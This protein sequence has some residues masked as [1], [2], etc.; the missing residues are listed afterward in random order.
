MRMNVNKVRTA[1]FVL[2]KAGLWGTVSGDDCALRLTGEEWKE[3]YRLAGKQTVTGIVFD[4]MT[5][6]PEAC[7]PPLPLLMKW[8]AE[9]DRVERTNRQMNK[10]TGELSRLFAEQGI[11]AVLLKGQGVAACYQVPLHRV[12]GD[13]DW[14]FPAGEDWEKAAELIK[15]Q[16]VET[17]WQPGFSMEYQWNGCVI[18]HHKRVLDV[19]NPFLHRYVR[20]LLN[21]EASHGGELVIGGGRVNLLS[22]LLVHLSVNMHILK[23]MLAVGIGIR[24]LCDVACIY[25]YY[26]KETDGAEL[27]RIYHKLGVFRWIQVLDAVLVKYLGVPEEVL[28]FPLAGDEQAEWMM[29]DILRA[30]NFGFYDERFSAGTEEGKGRRKKVA[31]QILRRFGMNVCYAPAE[32]CWFPVVQ[33]CSHIRFLKKT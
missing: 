21:R 23:H 28:P 24:Q 33:A 26:N 11:V 12:C 8:T 17:A 4:G 27:K 3:L 1:F 16:G 25:R 14:C 15:H 5:V 18:E 7:L 9:V 20:R 29:E 6:M 31:W 19:H 2:L 10:V 22:P 30:G 13:V 32:A